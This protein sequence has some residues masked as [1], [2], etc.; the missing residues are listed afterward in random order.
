MLTAESNMVT[1]Y[2]KL[3]TSCSFYCLSFN[4]EK[5]T[6]NKRIKRYLMNFF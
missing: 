4:V 2:I 6:K 5:R 1:L 3:S